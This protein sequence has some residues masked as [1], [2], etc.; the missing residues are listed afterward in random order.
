MDPITILTLS[1][2]MIVIVGWVV[3]THYRLKDLEEYIS[4]V[5]TDLNRVEDYLEKSSREEVMNNGN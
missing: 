2:T 5:D 3:F 1:F 4:E